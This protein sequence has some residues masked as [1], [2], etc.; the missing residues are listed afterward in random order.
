[1]KLK[2]FLGGIFFLLV[3][4]YFTYKLVR[5]MSTLFVE[6]TTMWQYFLSLFRVALIIFV[7]NLGLTLIK[8]FFVKEKTV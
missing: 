7:F 3:A 2:D 8:R 6:S 1:M 5:D 4:C